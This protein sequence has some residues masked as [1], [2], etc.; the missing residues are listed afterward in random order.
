M[1]PRAI[2]D[3]DP[4][5]PS[6]AAATEAWAARVRADHEQVD[7][8]REVADPADFYGPHARRFDHDPRRTDEPTLEQLLSL[9]EAGDTWLDL[10]A[11]G[12]RY[13]LPLA[14]HAT[15]VHAVEPSPAMVEV[16]RAGMARHGIANVTIHERSWPLSDGPV[17]AAE[18]ALLAHVGYDIEAFGA[19]LDA[20]E[21]AVSRRCVAIMRT[22]PGTSARWEAG[23]TRTPGPSA[24]PRLWQELHGE[25]RVEL[26][27]LAE[28]LV[29]LV[30]RGS[31]PEVTMHE[32]Q[33]WGH[34]SMEALIESTRQMLWLRPGSARDRRMVALVT[35][36]ATERDG[37][38]ALDWT[39]LPEGVVSW[40]PRRRD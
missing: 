7:R 16:L 34:E 17:P 15:H 1:A 25:P 33:A 12:G 37:M 23:P 40:E 30:A 5:R 32:R 35:E 19:F 4:L 39:P 24:R 28:L 6:E 21:A 2:P 14:L 11:G 36:R 22:S 3:P 38:W 26:P 9:V 10:G 29:L 18:V 13:T 8:C 31:T 20:A 27:M